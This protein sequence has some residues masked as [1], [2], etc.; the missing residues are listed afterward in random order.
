[1]GALKFSQIVLA[2]L[3][4]TFLTG[5]VLSAA[6]YPAKPVQIIEGKGDDLAEIALCFIH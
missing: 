2:I 5:G 1:M 4:L 6:E 3:T